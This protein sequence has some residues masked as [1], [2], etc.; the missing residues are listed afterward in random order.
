MFD[1]LLGKEEKKSLAIGT[2]TCCKCGRNHYVNSKNIRPKFIGVAVPKSG[3]EY[4][5]HPECGI[6]FDEK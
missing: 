4:V 5:C 3:V 2:V 1:D 6:F